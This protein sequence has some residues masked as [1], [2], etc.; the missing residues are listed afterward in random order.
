MK[1]GEAVSEHVLDEMSLH[2]AF[3][4]P[5]LESM[6]FL[7]EI[8]KRHPQAISFAPG[9]PNLMFLKDFDYNQ[10]IATYL[11][12]VQ[13]TRN[14]TPQEA[15]SLLY[16]YGPAQGLI[17]DLVGEALRRDEELHIRREDIVITVGAQ[18]AMFLALR[19]LFRDSHDQL[20]VVTPCY[21]GIQGAA[22]LLGI[23]LVPVREAT[24]G[25]DLDEL[26]RHVVD[27][28]KAGK[29]I[30]AIY[31]SPDYANPSGSVMSLSQRRR[32]LAMAESED[33][34]ILEDNAYG[35]TAALGTRVPSLKALDQAKR[36]IFIGTFAKICLPGARVG[37]VV[38]DQ[39]VRAD[40]SAPRSLAQAMASAKSMI[41]VNTS[42]ICQA[43]IGG[44]L[45]EHGGSLVKL[46]S[47]KAE[48]Y[49]RNLAHM[50]TALDQKLDPSVAK[51]NRPSG[52]F[53][54]LV[55]IPVRATA[56]LLED[57]ARRFGVLW[58]PMSQFHLGTAG[59]C[60]LRLSCSYLSLSQIDEGIERL[61][62]FLHT[63]PKATAA[64]F[65]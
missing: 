1:Q 50:I 15:M 43:V 16:E 45:L 25:A 2:S 59:D 56:E 20:A 61:S 13:V 47:D 24:D 35:F 4:E 31:I 63:L 29:A 44:M 28:R 11:K 10:S 39:L 6:N 49:R 23:E 22:S 54:V 8:M 26:G 53:F 7:N 40:T 30:R 46:G 41:T 19:A 42:P 55:R 3:S 5:A 51:W 52:G 27:A 9:A 58:T 57:C 64:T 65:N 37:F 17:C 34:Y 14:W 21:V 12:H 36:V 18:E 48:F 32:L 38:A 60:E 62:R 33:F